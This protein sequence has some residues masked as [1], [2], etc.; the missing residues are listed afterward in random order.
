MG[1]MAVALRPRGII[2]LCCK[3]S[4]AAALRFKIGVPVIEA[5]FMAS[6][7]ATHRP[8]TRAPPRLP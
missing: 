5:S 3:F 6:I 4:H 2:S 8:P 7:A 1:G